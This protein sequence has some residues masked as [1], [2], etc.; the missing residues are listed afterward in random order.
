[1]AIINYRATNMKGGAC[2]GV[3]ARA[4]DH[5]VWA[6]EGAGMAVGMQRSMVVEST[7][8]LKGRVNNLGRPEQDYTK[9]TS[10]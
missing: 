6:G 9:F 4:S 5:L 7:W 2:M 8:Y 3:H 10:S 1:M